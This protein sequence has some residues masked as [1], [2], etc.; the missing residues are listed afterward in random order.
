MRSVPT[1]YKFV[2]GMAAVLVVAAY[3][4]LLRDTEEQAASAGPWGM[5]GNQGPVAVNTASVEKR[6][7]AVRANFVGTLEGIAFAE[8]YPKANGQIVAIFAQT[9]D[10]VRQGQVLAQIDP[11]EATERVRAAEA[12]LRMAEASLAQ[13]E[14]SLTTARLAAERAASLFE[15]NL[16]SDQEHEDRQ[17]ALLS[18]QAQSRVAQA[19][20]EQAQ[21]ALSS[22]RLEL[23]NTRLRAPFTGVIG[24]R[25]MDVGNLAGNTRPIFTIVDVSTIRTTVP[26]VERDATFIR[27]GQ[28]ARVTVP[29]L[30]GHTFEGTV[31]RISPIFN[32]DT[33]STDA[34]IEIENAELLLSPGMLVNVSIGYR[35][36]AE[37]LL[38]PRASLIESEE[39]TY[40]FVVEQEDSVSFRAK[41]VVVRVLGSDDRI[42]RN[43]VAIDGL[44]DEGAQVIT[45]G[46]ESLRDGAAIRPNGRATASAEPR[47]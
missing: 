18:A 31:A 36:E 15:K 26:L 25:L 7:F 42:E 33:G 32:R 28:P 17:A 19:Q 43:L 2:I 11:A 22:A 27:A 9:G 21:A 1:K 6:N 13:Q 40:V 39:E 44:V 37:A 35:G 38:V 24:R 29:T 30:P 16:V 41:Q 4:L 20:V 3:F 46:H 8:L 12:S 45:L 23:E 5:G 47:A 34:E 14:A 10:P